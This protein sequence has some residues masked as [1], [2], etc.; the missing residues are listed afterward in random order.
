MGVESSALLWRWLTDPSSRWFPLCNLIVIIAQV[1]HES[2][3]TKWLMEH[4]LF[5]RLR[6]LRVRTVQVARAGPKVADGIAVLADTRAPTTCFTE[7]VYTLNDEL[8]AAGTVPQIASGR[9]R[10]SCR[11]KGEPLDWWLSQEF[12]DR[13]YLHTMGFGCHEL[14]RVERDRSYATVQRATRYPLVTW[15]WDRERCEAYL[16]EQTGFSWVKSACSTCPF[17]NGREHM[18][19]RYREFPDDAVEA[20]AVEARSVCLNERMTLFKDRSLYSVIVADGN[21][22][23]LDRFHALLD[24]ASWALY[25]VRRVIY[26]VGV[27][28]RKVVTLATGNRK[29]MQ[30][31][32][33][34]RARLL[35]LPV[36][37]SKDGRYE[38]VYIRDREGSYPQLEHVLTI[39]LA[40]VADKSRDRFEGQWEATLRPVTHIPLI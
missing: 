21:Q 15:G 32:L 30:R 27:A 9:R 17:S 39:G 12:G 1:G 33:K 35:K 2:A 18:L 37:Q 29:A 14:R 6:E 22:E 5:P 10:C 20:L 19:E 3:R 8:T 26:G 23:A 11:F 25:E 34:R 40:G 31:E 24:T 36:V 7:G 38:R 16:L 4:V 28:D 13:P